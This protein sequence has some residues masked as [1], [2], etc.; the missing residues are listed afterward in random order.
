VGIMRDWIQRKYNETSISNLFYVSS[1][2][3]FLLG[4]V[5]SRVFGGLAMDI[6]V[7][8]GLAGVIGGF[9]A[10]CMPAIRWISDAWESTLGKIA[11][12]LLHF[13]VLL[14]AT[15]MA[16]SLV[17]ES[18]GLPPQSFD[19]TVG[20]LLVVFYIPAL[21]VIASIAL[22]CFALVIGVIG[23][24][25]MVTL[26]AIQMLTPVL[27]VAGL[28]NKFSKPTALAMLNSMGALMMVLV[29]VTGSSYMTG[30]HRAWVHTTVKVIAVLSDFQSAKDYPGAENGDK[31]H[32]LENGLVAY[33]K[34]EADRSVSIFLRKQDDEVTPHQIGTSI[35]SIKQLTMPLM[36]ALR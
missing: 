25:Q 6:A 23:G 31:I 9:V 14:M 8:I 13:V 22:L 34:V 11:V 35:P 1:M 4:M 7:T 26:N 10:W 17:S 15:S 12:A 24:I 28:K 18:L 3:I 30:Q 20:F 33:A 29:L 21:M 2:V 32:P 36:D 27:N 5:L 16:R 19:L